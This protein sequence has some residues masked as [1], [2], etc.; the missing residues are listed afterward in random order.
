MSEPNALLR[1]TLATL[2]YRAGKALRGA[3]AAFANFKASPQTRTPAE[4]LAHMGDLFDWAVALAD[5]RHDW[6]DS[7]PLP[8][9]E[10]V[11]RFFDALARFDQRL[12]SPQPLG[13]EPERLF[14]GPIADGLSHTGQMAMLRRMAGAPIRAENY[15]RAD[16]A[17]GR[18]D[19]DQPAP[20]VEFD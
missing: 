4:I 15:F 13:S 6:H 19:M 7:Q 18:V 10:E 2:A 9:D 1:H 12:A 20:E 8:W 14:A 11:R 16:I 3:P 17:A 5:G